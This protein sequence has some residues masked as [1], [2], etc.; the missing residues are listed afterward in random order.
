MGFKSRF[1]LFFVFH[2]LIKAQSD[3]I[4]R[5]N[6]QTEI[7]PTN[8]EIIIDG[9]KNEEVWKTCPVI[10]DFFRITP[11]DTGYA[12]AQTEVQLT[13]DNNYLYAAI[14]LSLIHI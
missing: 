5:K 4:N 14:I 9:D 7:S 2:F 3:P 13:Y 12:S 6:F 11:V 1:L 10:K 8:E